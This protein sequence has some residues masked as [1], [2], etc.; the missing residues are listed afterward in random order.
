VRAL[1]PSIRTT[2]LVGKSRVDRER[3]Q[4]ADVVRWAKDAGVTDL[5]VDHRVLD[6]A[7]VEA[8]RTA[9]FRVATWTVNEE[10]DIRR[11]IDLGVDIVISDRPDLALRLT[12]R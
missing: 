9:G 4:S 2:L 7:L 8:A 3:A 10:P 5:G 11:V 6:G 1:D 12:R